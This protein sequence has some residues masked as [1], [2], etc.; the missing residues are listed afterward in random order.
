M[1]EK[2]SPSRSGVGPYVSRLQRSVPPDALR[3]SVAAMAPVYGRGSAA[4][5]AAGA[6][7]RL[8]ARRV[9]RAGEHEEQVGEPVEVDRRERV[10][11]PFVGGGEDV[12]L[13]PAARGARDVE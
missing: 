2:S 13:G 10:H 9:R 12:A 6:P 3:S 5:L 8:R 1:V 4:P 11:G 7:E